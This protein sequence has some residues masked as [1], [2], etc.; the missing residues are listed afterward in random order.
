MGVNLSPAQQVSTS[1]VP[2][3]LFAVPFLVGAVVVGGV[4]WRRR[5]GWA[6]QEIRTFGHA[7]GLPDPAEDLD[8]VVQRVRARLGGRLA[9][10]VVGFVVAVPVV[11]LSSDRVGTS[12]RYLMLVPLFGVLGTC[13]GH[14][15][16]VARA[17]TSRRVAA[18][19]ERRVSDYVTRVE[20]WSAGIC[21]ALPLVPL[22]LGGLLWARG[23]S[24]STAVVLSLVF[25]IASMAAIVAMLLLTRRALAQNVQTRGASGLAWAELLRAQMLRD[26]VGGVTVLGAV[27]GALVLFFG[28][29]DGWRDYPDWYIPA[30]V[31]T[32]V[33]GGAALLAG[34]AAAAAD[35]DLRWAREH[36]LGAPGPVAT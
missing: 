35:T 16:P 32:T 33:L 19:R 28:V 14:M 30:M 18:L 34:L 31:V 36:I 27:G 23:N 11:G 10:A 26:L 15:W 12:G 22:V 24:A 25:V 20:L 13:V 8:W 29:A 17:L 2:S 6:A 7:K 5:E 9:G 21:G 4:L 3:W 1:E